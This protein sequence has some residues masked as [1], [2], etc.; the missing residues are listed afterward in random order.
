MFFFVS[1]NCKYNLFCVEY[2]FSDK[3]LFIQN[4]I[5]HYMVIIV[6]KQNLYN[7]NNKMENM[8]IEPMTSSLLRK[9][10]ATELI[11]LKEHK[12]YVSLI[13]I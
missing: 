5:L 8:G 4:K 6:Y 12:N 10:S 1:S 9:R 2:Y 13:H 11:P 7:F 3:M